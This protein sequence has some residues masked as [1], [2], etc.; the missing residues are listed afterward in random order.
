MLS[1]ISIEILQ[2]CPNRC[3]YCSS[4]SNPQAAY[5]IPFEIIK[6]VIDDAK[7]LGCKTVC[8]SGGEPFLH[9]Q[10]LD[11]ISY[12]AKQQLTCYV[13]T[14]GIYMKDE[15][16]SSLPN[17]Y[18]EAIRGMVDKVIFNVEA[19]SS[20]LYDQIMGTDVGGFDMMKKSINDCV[21][22]G[23]VVETHVVPMQVNFK[24]LKSIFEMCYQLGVSK[25]SILRLVLQGRALENL[26]LVKLSGEDNWKV[27]KLIKTLN[28]SY[29]G[30][31]RIGL[32]YSDSN[33]RIYC[34]AASDK[35]NVRY[36][37]N[38]YPCEVFK[39]DLLNAKLGCEPDNVWKDSFYNIYQHSPYLNVVRKSIEAFK[40]E[41]GDETC[42]GQFKMEK[43]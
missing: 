32:P 1:E 38:V 35:I 42:Y 37:G 31:V 9:P 28:E 40:K 20:A 29:K 23:L 16:Y 19:D 14:S 6:N 4:H 12:I 10:I 18:I 33:C 26:S 17:E 36:D 15:V 8:L 27:T 7:S 21:S 3:I 13:Y 30:K 22:S 39:D 41:D 43:I 2:R 25:V 34:K 24:H 11:I 5:L